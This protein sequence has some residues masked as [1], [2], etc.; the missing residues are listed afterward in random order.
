MLPILKE[1]HLL[2]FLNTFT[3][4]YEE[5]EHC[6]GSPNSMKHKIIFYNVIIC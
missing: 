3:G 2:D 5:V 6:R 1:K 4:L